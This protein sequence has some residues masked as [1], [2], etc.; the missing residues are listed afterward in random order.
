MDSHLI[1][2]SCSKPQHQPSCMSVK[3]SG[4][5]TWQ[6]DQWQIFTQH[7]I[8]FKKEITSY[9]NIVNI[10]I[11]ETHH[12]SI[13]FLLEPEPMCKLFPH[14]GSDRGFTWRANTEGPDKARLLMRFAIRFA[15]PIE[16]AS[17]QTE[18]NRI[19]IN[20]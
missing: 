9:G 10:S 18:Y 7:D 19:C 3:H 14:S 5:Y 17:F 12:V 8:I 4:F 20:N 16:A 6:E 13:T 2:N 1:E 11:P 15:S